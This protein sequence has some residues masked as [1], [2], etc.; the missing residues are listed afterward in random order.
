MCF[1]CGA[2]V[3]AVTFNSYDN[4]CYGGGGAGGIL[5]AQFI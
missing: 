5:K 2:A 3:L 1:L 4:R